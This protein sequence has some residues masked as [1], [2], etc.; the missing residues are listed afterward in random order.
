M[1]DDDKKHEEINREMVGFLKTAILFS[2]RGAGFALA[3]IGVFLVQG[4]HMYLA[5]SIITPF[6][7]G[8]IKFIVCFFGAIFLS[9]A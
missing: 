3:F 7:N 8:F 5:F 1:I 9:G 2:S 4:F 6:D